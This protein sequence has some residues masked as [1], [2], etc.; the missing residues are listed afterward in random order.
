MAFTN[1]ST[2]PLF[3]T[4]A[5]HNADSQH[6]RNMNAMPLQRNREEAHIFEQLDTLAA[7]CVRTYP[8]DRPPQMRYLAR[9]V[10]EPNEA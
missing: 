7:T 8:A 10:N 9:L 6:N 4:S 3:C 2:R 1:E 5:V